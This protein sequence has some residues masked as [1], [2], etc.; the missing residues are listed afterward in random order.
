MIYT[1]K[2]NLFTSW[3]TATGTYREEALEQDKLTIVNFLQNKGY[4]DAKVNIWIKEAKKAGKIII[5]IETE[6]GA[7]FHFN[8]VTYEGNILFDDKEIETRFSVRPEAIYSPEKLRGTADAIKEMYGRKG[9]IDATVEYETQLVED[10]P[11]YNVHFK[12]EEGQQYKIGL[13]RVFGN[14]QTQTGVILHES[15]LIPGEKFDSAKLKATQKRLESMGYFKNVNVYAVRSKEDQTLGD[16]YRD[17]YI[18]VEET[19]TGNVSLFFGF[20]T[21]DSGFG[22]LELAENNFNYKGIPQLFSKGYRA[23][24]GG[25]EYAHMRFNVGARQRTYSLAWV[26]P[27]FRDSLWRVGFNAEAGHS[28]LQSKDYNINTLGLSVFASYPLSYQ[29]TFGT[30]Y[31][32]RYSRNRIEHD[33]DKKERQEADADGV[34]SA[35]GSSLTYDTTDSALKPH[36]GLRS[37]IDAE[38]AGLGGRWHFLRYGFVNSYY[39]QLWKGGIMKYRADLRFIEPLLSTNHASDIPLSER[40]F[41]GGETSVRGFVPFSLG[42]HFSN[43]APSGGISSTLLSIE[44]LHELFSFLDPFVFADAGNVERHRFFIGKLRLSYG[45]GVRLDI[46]KR[47]PMIIGMGFPVNNGDKHNV[48]R[49]FFSMG[50]QF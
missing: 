13:I 35:I 6:R 29:W 2:Y 5:K 37:I 24:R 27:Y 23:I 26:T 44:Y 40:F 33:H 46:M 31:R 32:V 30:K 1:K 47:L 21:A 8:K 43:G 18:E 48:R 41:L 42:P 38:F 19:T 17:V 15:L 9:Y 25:G 7:L 11:L 50:G 14:I 20:S 22:G 28:S 4:A 3:L 39:T 49:F 10:A 12:V 36:N 16:N 45:F 34:I